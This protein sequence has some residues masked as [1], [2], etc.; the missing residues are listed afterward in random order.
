MDP[1]YIL[2]RCRPTPKACPCP[3]IPPTAGH[4]HPSDHDHLVDYQPTLEALGLQN[5][6]STL[7]GVDAFEVLGGTMEIEWV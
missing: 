4:P 1:E 5:H 2:A 3:T 7:V 6:L